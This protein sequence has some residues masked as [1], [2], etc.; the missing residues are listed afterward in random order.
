MAK[1]LAKGAAWWLLGVALGASLAWGRIAELERKLEKAEA[2]ADAIS[3]EAESWL[4]GQEAG[5]WER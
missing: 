3:W 4:A 2:W 5:E 1:A